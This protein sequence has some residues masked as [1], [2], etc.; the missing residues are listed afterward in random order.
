[1]RAIIAISEILA[2][3]YKYLAVSNEYKDIGSDSAGQVSG[4]M[5]LLLSTEN[6]SLKESHSFSY[7][8]YRS[9]YSRPSLLRI[10]RRIWKKST[11]VARNPIICTNGV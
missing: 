3:G 8:L 2:S 7:Y 11:F 1:M 6:A 10:S 9:G 5:A 4:I